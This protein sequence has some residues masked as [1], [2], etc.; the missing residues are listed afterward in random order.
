MIACEKVISCH[1]KKE[2]IMMICIFKR[3]LLLSLLCTPLLTLGSCSTNPA[4]GKKSFTAFMSEE[5]EKRVGAAEHPKILKQF[6][7]VYDDKNLG[8]YVA[9]IGAKL[10]RHSEFPNLDFTFTV[11][12][13]DKVN[14]FALPGGYIYITRGL[15]AITTNEAEMAGVLA[16]EIGHVTA[17]HSSQRYSATMA[18]NIGLKILGV[19]GRAAGAPSGTGQLVSFGAQAALKSYSREQ[20]LESDMLG[21]RYLKLAGYDPQAMVS[22]FY[23]LQGHSKLEAKMWGKKDKSTADI[24]S[25]HPLTS[26]RIAAA[27]KL[28]LDS[29]TIGRERKKKIFESKIN[30]LV[31]GDDP[32]QGIRRGRFF[33]HPKLGIRF[34]VPPD[35]SMI[36]TPKRLIAKSKE[37]SVIFFDMAL[38][39][40]VQELGGIEKYL[41]A[42]NFKGGRFRDIK[43]IDINGL[44]AVTGIANLNIAGKKRDVKLFVIKKNKNQIFRLWFETDPKKTEAWAADINKTIQSFTSLD[45]EEV[46]KIKPLRIR[47]KTILIG[48]NIDEIAERM[49]VE[50]FAIDWLELLNGINRDEPLKAGTRIRI[51]SQ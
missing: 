20:E 9:S 8:F 4:T 23:K 44:S 50:R 15:L 19:I 5:E 39:K 22:F 18:T 12:N 41:K 7:G 29:N 28:S 11:L 43:Q 36:N 40:K 10:A 42:I 6:G 47:F 46:S 1:K 25:T 32:D 3:L 27:E 24:M 34:E 16:H 13:T 2:M 33:E 17:R 38:E 51:I 31:F 30:G 21:V 45:E 49:P 14:A 26:E 35:F 37:N 48:E